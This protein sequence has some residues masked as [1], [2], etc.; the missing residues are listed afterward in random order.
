MKGL[1][2]RLDD[3]GM[4]HA[5]NMAAKEALELGIPI[6]ASVMFACPWQQ[7]AVELLKG[8]PQA[9]VGVHLTLNSEWKDYRWGPVAGASQV[10]SLVDDGGYFWPTHAAFDSH[11]VS[12]K[13]VE[14][15]LR[16]QMERALKSGLRIDYMDHHMTTAVGTL[17]LREL[18]ERL[19]AEYKLPVPRYFGEAVH[20]IF[21]DPPEAKTRNLAAIVEGLKEGGLDLLVFHLGLKTPEMDALVDMDSA[22]MRGPQGES[23]VSTHRDAERRALLSVEFKAALKKSGARLLN[24]RDLAADPGIGAMR[25][26]A[27]N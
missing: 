15:E 16:A 27:L 10:P 12:L 11:A 25:R 20:T 4:C 23:L 8:H 9:A 26:P 22:E 14:G 7:E 5:G 17:E 24:Y 13:D 1:L 21:S 3:L 6:S 19:A 2:L 18:F